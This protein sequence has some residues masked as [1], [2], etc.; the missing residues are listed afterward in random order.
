MCLRV[1]AVGVS[2]AVFGINVG[3]KPSVVKQMVVALQMTKI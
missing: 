2:M 1:C 3:Q